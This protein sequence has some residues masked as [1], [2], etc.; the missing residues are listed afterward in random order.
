[1]QRFPIT[2]DGYAKMNEE[3]QN[4][5][6]IERPAVIAAIA[7]ARGHGDLSEN[8]EYEAAK[9]KQ[10]YIEAK[11]ADLESKVAR[12][13]IISN[14]DVD[15]TK[16]QFGA[17]VTLYDLDSEKNLEYRIVGDYEA[18]LTK[19]YVSIFS[20][21]AKSLIGKKRGDEVEVKTPG[22]LKFYDVV[23]IRYD[24]AS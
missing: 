14:R 8:A 1:M 22:G 21:I 12:S 10:G 16:I 7:E 19:K 3:L 5:K 23:D 24:D 20:P 18:D 4:L 11:I 6:N 2:S 17:Y 15:T 13:Q 9:E